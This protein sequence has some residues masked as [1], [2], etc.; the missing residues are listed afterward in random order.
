MTTITKQFLKALRPDLDKH[1]SLIAASHGLTELRCGNARFDPEAGTF[2]M[3]IEGVAEGAKGVEAAIYERE[4]ALYGLP[5]IGTA[6]KHSGD[7]WT[8][9]GMKRS[10]KIVAQ[11]ESSGKKYLFESDIIKLL[12]KKAA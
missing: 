9:V 7:S 1:L 8:I 10:G 2:T 4:G 5:P 6:F 11:R 12:T 3:T